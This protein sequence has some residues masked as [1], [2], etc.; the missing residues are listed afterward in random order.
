LA[1][2]VS[3]TMTAFKSKIS[4]SSVSS[5]NRSAQSVPTAGPITKV[6]KMIFCLVFL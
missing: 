1:D 5:G 6:L 2:G 3:Q 4:A